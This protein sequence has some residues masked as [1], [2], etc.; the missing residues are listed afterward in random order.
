[1]DI[2]IKTNSGK[3]KALNYFQ[4]MHYRQYP[5]SVAK[6]ILLLKIERIFC[7]DAEKVYDAMLDLIIN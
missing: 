4:R 7:G 3:N 5:D 2:N 6:D 1:M